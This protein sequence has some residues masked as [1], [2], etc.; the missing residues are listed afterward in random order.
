MMAEWSVRR[1]YGT[2]GVFLQLA[3]FSR[4]LA[5]SVAREEHG[6]QSRGRGVS[7]STSKYRYEKVTD[8]IPPF[9]RLL[10]EWFAWCLLRAVSLKS[11][12][13]IERSRGKESSEVYHRL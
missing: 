7:A 2:Y 10:L 4:S 11:R 6:H 3:S 12:W 13:R 8:L 1:C 9:D 5:R